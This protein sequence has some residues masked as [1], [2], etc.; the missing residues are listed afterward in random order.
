MKHILIIL[1]L[2]NAFIL[3]AKEID[4]NW[5]NKQPKSI[6]KDFYIWR[7]LNQNIT[8]IQSLKAVEQVK[9][10]NKKIFYRFVDKYKDNSFIEYKSCMKMN[11]KD[12]IKQN[13]YC[14]ES[15]LSIFDATKLSKEELNFTI[16][17]IEN[18]YPELNNKLSVLNSIE[19]FNHLKESDIDIFFNVFNECG[20][21]Y[22]VENLNYFF[23][24]DLIKK[25]RNDKR[26]KQTIK[27][28]VTNNKMDKSQLSL[29]NIDDK[30]FD[31]KTTFYL[32]INAIKQ[33]KKN[34]ALKYLNSSYKKA[35]Y[36]MDK[37]NVLFWQYLLTNEKKY[38]IDLS[39]SW[40]I[41]IYSLYASEI[42]NKKQNNI[43][44]YI[45]QEKGIKS[46]F[47]IKNPFEWL[48]ILEESRKINSTKLKKYR[49]LFK[50]NETLGHLAFIKERYYKYKK[51]YFI[52]PYENFIGDLDIDRKSL[53]YAIARQESRFIPTSISSAYAMGSMQIM[54]FLSKAISK[55]LKEDYDIDKQLEPKTNLKYANFQLDFLERRLKHP[56]L[57]SYGYN[58]GIGFTKRVLKNGLFKKNRYEP[59]LSMELIP[60][61]ETKKYGKKVLANYFVYYNYLNKNKKIKLKSLFETIN[62]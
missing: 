36:Q 21:K 54:P 5:I 10:L 58:G 34:I 24:S 48:N 53:I 20:G 52:T 56:L 42:L 13:D 33:N 16:K 11:T 22:R 61:E 39:K 15:G 43:I 23:T 30:G 44:F 41:N 2:I 8:P 32:A 4:L 60:Y 25:L 26:F 27:L 55:S 19:P 29:L 7:Y 17:K 6:A 47:N 51:S 46:S 35:Y 28:I 31:F 3:N 38:L 57:I 45:E 14:I 1:L 49:S 62:N 9:Y 37:D 59:F 40:D 50:T 12:L 18:N